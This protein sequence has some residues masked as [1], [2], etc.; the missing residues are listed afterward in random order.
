MSLSRLAEAKPAAIPTLPLTVAVASREGRP[1]VGDDWVKRQVSESQRLMQPHGVMVD[2]FEQRTLPAEHAV[3]ETADDRDAL[4]SFVKPKLINVFVVASLRDIDDETRLRM[5]VRWRLRRDLRKDY[6]IVAA[7]ALDTTLCH[8]LGHFF[9]NGHSQVVDNV[10]SYKREN[11]DK[12]AFDPRQGQKMR[13]VAT[14]LLRTG[15]VA[16]LESL[17]ATEGEREA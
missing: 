8:E 1:V 14:R 15:K 7:R 6:V 13:L 4:H 11:P 12:V 16:T 10:M 2:L 17:R 3:L 9:G 5:G